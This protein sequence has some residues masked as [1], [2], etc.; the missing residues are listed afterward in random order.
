MVGRDDINLSRDISRSG[1]DGEQGIG[2]RRCAI[3]FGYTVRP[4]KC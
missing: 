1:G 4:R 2:V 3:W